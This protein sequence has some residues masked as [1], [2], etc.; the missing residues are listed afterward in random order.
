TAA[1]AG[2]AAAP[3]PAAKAG[4]APRVAK[5]AEAGAALKRPALSSESKPA[6]AAAAG[7]DDDWETF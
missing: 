7:S 2:A 6:L 4:Y 1:R 3:A 5:G